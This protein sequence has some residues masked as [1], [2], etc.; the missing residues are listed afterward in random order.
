MRGSFNAS[1]LSKAIRIKKE[2]M[3]EKIKQ[4]INH[5]YIEHTK[6]AHMNVAYVKLLL[7]PEMGWKNEFCLEVYGQTHKREYQ[8]LGGL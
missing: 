4:E 5:N 2:K 1:Q 3:I 8:N 7:S 6:Y